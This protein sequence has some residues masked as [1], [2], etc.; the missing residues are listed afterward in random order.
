[1]NLKTSTK[2]DVLLKNDNFQ[3]STND[4][5]YFFYSSQSFYRKDL[6]F[7]QFFGR[8]LCKGHNSKINRFPKTQKTISANL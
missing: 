5:S 7:Q 2:W 8:Y 6:K 1:M 4:F 3:L